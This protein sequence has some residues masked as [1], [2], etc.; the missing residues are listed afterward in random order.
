MIRHQRPLHKRIVKGRDIKRPKGRYLRWY[1]DDLNR[2]QVVTV[3]EVL[4]MYWD[5]AKLEEVTRSSCA[6]MFGVLAEKIGHLT[7]ADIDGRIALKYARERGESGATVTGFGRTAPTKLGPATDTTV[8]KEWKWLR[9]SVRFAIKLGIVEPQYA[10]ASLVTRPSRHK[11][12]RWLSKTEVVRILEL[13]YARRY[14]RPP[15]SLAAYRF[16]L[17]AI[18]TGAR[19]TAIEHL[20]WKDID[21]EAGT[22]DFRIPGKAS[23]V[24]RRVK[25][26]MMP[27]LIEALRLERAEENTANDVRVLGDYTGDVFKT[28][29]RSLANIGYPNVNPH[30]FR[31]TWATLAVQDGVPSKQAADYLGMS[32]Q[33]FRDTYAHHDPNYNSAA[34]NRRFGPSASEEVQDP[35]GSSQG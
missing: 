8:W 13:M 11:D 33:T 5:H 28:V 32:E 6:A 27:E 4:R 14:A 29:T 21:W 20:K 9:A 24:K 26:K 12:A 17:I 10:I 19:R 25:I 35:N 22:L 18:Y 15:F 2:G 31:H 30:M 16:V 7:V 1:E 23:R 34:V 3:N